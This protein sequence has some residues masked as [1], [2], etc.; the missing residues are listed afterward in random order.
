MA[1]PDRQ[2]LFLKHLPSDAAMYIKNGS[3]Q[4][5]DMEVVYQLARVWATNSRSSTTSHFRHSGKPLIKFGKRK[6]NSKST[7]AT[8]TSTTKDESS[9]DDALDVINL[10]IT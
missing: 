4:S 10:N 8:S 6:S 9:S 3:L 1:F 2:R 7:P 5:A